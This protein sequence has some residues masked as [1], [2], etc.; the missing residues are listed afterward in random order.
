MTNPSLLEA[1][2]GLLHE[3]RRYEG[4]LAQLDERHGST[5]PHV[6][7]RVRSD[8]TARLSVVIERLQERAVDLEETAAELAHR[9]A[10]LLETETQRRDERAEAE[11]RAA[12][13][14]YTEDAAR[15]ILARC[16]EEI[17]RLAGERSALGSELARVQEVLV[18]AQPPAPAA[19]EEPPDE[20]APEPVQASAPQPPEH[21][22]AH[23]EHPAS[24]PRQAFDEL[25]FLQSVVQS[26]KAPDGPPTAASTHAVPPSQAPT[27]L[28]EEQAASGDFAPPMP[29]LRRQ[30][31][32]HGDQLAAQTSQVPRTMSLSPEGV[33]SFFKDVPSEQAKTLKCQECGT[34]NYPTEWYCERCGGELA[35]M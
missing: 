29:G 15:D 23:G 34:M 18:A 9:I 35:A 6:L 31:T 14:E 5:P 7:D 24:A 12:V 22:A 19:V 26:K 3:R 11:L 10:A 27:P 2:S 30:V 13:G 4:W 32:P 17:S 33:A 8:Y 20:P 16:D 21:A 25:A 28:R 1:L